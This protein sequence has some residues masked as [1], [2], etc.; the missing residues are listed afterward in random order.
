[1]EISLFDKYFNKDD[2][3]ILLNFLD[4]TKNG[5]KKITY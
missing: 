4:N 5:K 2:L 3:N 1:M